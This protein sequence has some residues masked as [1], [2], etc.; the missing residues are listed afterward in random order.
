M[1]YVTV[2]LAWLIPLGVIT[3]TAGG[4]YVMYLAAGVMMWVPHYIARQCT[5]RIFSY[6][7]VV[8]WLAMMVV[9]M[10]PLIHLVVMPDEYTQSTQTCILEQLFPMI[11]DTE[12]KSFVKSTLR[13]NSLALLP[14]SLQC[15][16]YAF[17]DM[18]YTLTTLPSSGP[19]AWIGPALQSWQVWAY[20]RASDV[21]PDVA[22]QVVRSR[23]P[24]M[25]NAAL[26]SA[27]MHCFS[28]L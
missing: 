21:F 25:P 19:L 12:P 16:L 8:L 13:I 9:F 22:C 26:E 1:H 7:H 23:L 18:L 20:Q 5:A 2:L 6:A 11:D 17:Y 24:G 4:S 28:W 3:A 10:A 27:M 15:Q 14:K